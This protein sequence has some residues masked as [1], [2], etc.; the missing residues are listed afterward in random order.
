MGQGG[1]RPGEGGQACAF[2][3][4]E[5]DDEHVLRA[6][7]LVT[8]GRRESVRHGSRRRNGLI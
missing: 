3:L 1:D 5:A 8:V 4:I 6:T 7:M 2:L